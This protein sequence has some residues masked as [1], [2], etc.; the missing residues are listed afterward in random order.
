[1]PSCVVELTTSGNTSG[2]WDHD[3]LLQVFSN[4]VGNA[5]THGSSGCAVQLEADGREPSNVVAY[6]RNANAIDPE[7]LPVIFDPFRGGKKRHNAKGLGLGLF[8]TRQIVLAHGG[9]IAVTS[10]EAHGTLV[11]IKLPRFPRT[12]ET[13]T[14]TV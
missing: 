3:R 14:V 8:I 5:V 13:D 1:M 10:G 11:C 2:V 12:A 4:L 7:M 9:E 6:V